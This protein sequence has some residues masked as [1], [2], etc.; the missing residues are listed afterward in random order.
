M[1]INNT[2][3]IKKNIAIVYCRLSRVPDAT[4]GVLS[5]DSQEFAIKNFLR[6]RNM[7]IYSTLKNIGS[8]YKGPQTDLKNLLKSCK[9]KTLVVYEANRLSR[10]LN[11]FK[12]IY[13]I[14]EK[15]KH[16][17]AIVNMNT[18]FDHRVR[19]NY[20]ILHD[21]IAAAQKESADMGARISRTAR[22]NNSRRPAWGNMRDEH[23]NIVPNPREQKITKLIKL[24]STAGSSISEIK[25]LVTEVGKT[26]GKEPFEI[27]EYSQDGRTDLDTDRLPYP[28]WPINIAET[29]K[30]YEIRKRRARWTVNDI[31]VIIHSAGPTSPTIGRNINVAD[32]SLV[33]DLSND[34]NT[35]FTARP[36]QGA[37]SSNSNA[38]TS[39]AQEW[40]CIWYDPSVGLPPN[41]QIPAGMA[42][43]NTACSIYIPK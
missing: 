4:R 11:N 21:L 19:S 35:A 2:M 15:N 5:L 23:D 34:F 13:K 6:E 32:E 29:F 20:Q 36:Q 3:N 37:T 14:C 16:D 24:L 31:R 28:M 17:I 7:G 25:S 40:I 43:P 27:E 30:I 26:E 12:E 8:A 1:N 10:N 33:D 38:A 42:L 9:N 22:Y 41:V 18:I 39:S